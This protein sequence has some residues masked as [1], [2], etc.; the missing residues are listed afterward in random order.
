[1]DLVTDVS[2]DAP[3]DALT[4]YNVQLEIVDGSHVSLQRQRSSSYRTRYDSSIVD[5]QTRTR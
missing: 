3:I 2:V 1:M 4:D 5:G